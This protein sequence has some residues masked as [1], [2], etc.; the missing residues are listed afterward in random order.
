MPDV[1][2]CAPI[3]TTCPRDCYDA[4]GVLALRR[5]G[6]L[7]VRGDP[8]H[9]VSRGALCR[10]C[11]LAYNG[12][13]QDPSARLLRPLRR[14]GP[15]GEGR[16]EPVSWDDALA[17]AAA[18]LA[19][20]VE[21]HGGSAITN[22]HYTG[23]CALLGYGFPLRLVRRLGATEVEP[24]T[25]CN[26]AGHAA[27][28][29][30]YGTSVEG[31]DP[32]TARDATCILVWGANPSATAPHA[33]DHWLP[34]RRGAL[35]VVDPVATPTARDADLHLQPFPGTDAAL[36]FSLL[37]V[38]RREGLLDRRFLADH[39]LGWEEI[40][41]LLEACTPKWAQEQTGVP[42]SLI[43]EAAVLYGRGPSLLWIGQ[44]LQRQPL[45]GNIVR[46]VATL[47]AATG[48]IGKPG[49]GFLYLNGHRSRRIDDAY[50][51]APTLGPDNPT[52]GHMA[53]ASHLADPSRS[54]ALL[55]WNMNPAASNPEQRRLR[56]ALARD[57][58]FTVVID[59]FQTDTADFADLV[60][61]AASFL[62]HDDLVASYFNL[63]L[64]AQVKVSEPPG[65]ALPNTEIFRRL[66]AA[67]R[68]SEPELFESD[69]SLIDALLERTGLGVTWEELAARG[70]IW[71]SDE[72]LVQFPGLRFPTRSGK[73]ELASEAAEADGHPRTPLPLVDPKPSGGR[74]R[75]LSPA[76][77]WLMNASFANDAKIAKKL[78]R[79]TIGLTAHDAGAL[80]LEEGDRVKVESETGSLVLTVEITD[81]VQPGVAYAPKG[82]WPR[83]DGGANVNVLVPGRTS[84]MGESTCVHATEISIV[85][86]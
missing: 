22:V 67:L 47:P 64:S 66:A 2:A 74:L 37:H 27:L 43:E 56:E 1:P 29:Y 5:D 12:V 23:T 11:T 72:P 78:G 60:L 49:C 16:F 9:P 35:V 21:R 8:D 75:L 57:D 81:A 77:P 62:E 59:L 51:A 42:A 19:E 68:Y 63:S 32:R 33:H 48:N 6:R 70:T 53:L 36:A 41:P 80:G 44:G 10:K 31:F 73:A 69:R 79:P 58:L 13:L 76:S 4:C 26:L 20:I 7:V 24:D 18:R 61:P 55:C 17:E 65:E 39:T 38:V 82:R 46:A 85:R 15:K 34:E 40:E 52:I 84:D 71:V 3:R 86:D 30:M 28:E 45:G 50:I 83:L 25:V 14:T 54:R